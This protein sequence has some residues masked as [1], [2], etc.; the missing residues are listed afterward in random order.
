VRSSDLL[1][2]GRRKAGLSQAQL[3]ERLGRPQS[4]IARWE[5][6]HQRPPLESVIEALHACG[7]ELTFGLPRYDD[8]YFS[9][10]AQQ[11]RLDP[12]ERVT[13]LAR[14]A[15]G[16]D[17]IEMLCELAKDARFVVI[18]RVAGAFNGWPIILGTRVLHVVPADTSA[19][20]VEEAARGLGA[21]PAGEGEDGSQRWVL[22]SGAELHVSAVPP[23]TRGYRDLARDAESVQ[24]A[25][26]R[27]VSVASLI[28]LIRIAESSIGPEARTFVPAL[29][30]TL[31]MRQYW[32][33]RARA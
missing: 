16:Y 25:P 33:E 2:A 7:L 9:L 4:T 32:A 31:E 23:G 24:I 3:A 13:R 30:A 22:A 12:G 10:I 21:E 28:D 26:G 18:G 15:A 20:A 29:W 6:G 11:L 27:S 5:T 8:S 14:T 17:P 1:I 19:D